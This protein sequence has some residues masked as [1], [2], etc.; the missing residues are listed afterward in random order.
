MKTTA[1]QAKYSSDREQAR[2]PST[3][4]HFLETDRIESRQ[5]AAQIDDEDDDDWLLVAAL[6]KELTDGDSGL[7]VC[8]LLLHF[9]QLSVHLVCVA[10]QPQ[11]GCR[12]KTE[13]TG[14][15][16]LYPQT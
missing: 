2:K 14:V 11:Q 5:L 15:V 7:S 16:V 4:R 13:T 10:F 6:L 9:F 3:N 1:L 12:V 8:G